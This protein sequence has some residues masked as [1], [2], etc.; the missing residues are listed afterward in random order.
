MS[1]VG[2]ERAAID[3]PYEALLLAHAGKAAVVS[4]VQRFV[5][6]CDRV[7][8]LDT[9]GLRQRMFVSNEERR[10]EAAIVAVL[11]WRAGDVAPAVDVIAR[12]QLVTGDGGVDSSVSRPKRQKAAPFDSIGEC[13]PKIPAHASAESLCF[14]TWVR[15]LQ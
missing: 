15:S 10:I 6:K 3:M 7:K 4:E 11:G 14:S 13:D 12:V 8:F 2:F 9:H 1:G 5:A